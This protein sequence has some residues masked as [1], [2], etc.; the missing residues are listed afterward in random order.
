MKTAIAV[1]G[2]ASFALLGAPA[3]AAADKA[4]RPGFTELDK[5][6]DGKLSRTEAAGNPVLAKRFAE[7]DDDRDG[8]VTRVE[9]LKTMADEDWRNMR[10]NMADFIA[11]DDK[12]SA[13]GSGR[14]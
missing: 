11:P 10:E 12:A 6:S 5:N 3:Y 2:L 8:S 14:K 9:Y 13:G 1:A 4:Q 7:T